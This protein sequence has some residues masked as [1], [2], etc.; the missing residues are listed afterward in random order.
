M[1]ISIDDTAFGFGWENLERL[2]IDKYVLEIISWIDK[3]DK[4][5]HEELIKYGLSLGAED[6][7]W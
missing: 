4:L 5:D 6:L 1:L 3:V 7:S 2:S